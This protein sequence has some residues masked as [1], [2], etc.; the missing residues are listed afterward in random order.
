MD[1]NG[2]KALKACEE[3]LAIV[4]QENNVLRR[5]LA[6]QDLIIQNH[7]NSAKEFSLTRKDYFIGQIVSGLLA[8][9]NYGFVRTAF[10]EAEK[11]VKEILEQYEP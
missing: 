11:A 9:N 2:Y 10:S 3:Q 6:Q 7:S 8:T 1:S 5:R 4:N